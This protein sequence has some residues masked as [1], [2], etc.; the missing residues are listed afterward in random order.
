M[1]PLPRLLVSCLVC[2]ATSGLSPMLLAEEAPSSHKV[3]HD[4]RETH[5]TEV[6]QL[7][8]GG[9]NAEAY[10]SPEGH[11]LIYQA[12][13]PPQECDQIFRLRA[14]GKGEPRQVSTG[15]GRTTCAFFFPDGE[16]LLYASTHLSDAAC[17]ARPDSSQGY[18]WPIYNSFEIF[19]AK[20][21]GS[22]L[23]Q[24]T[25]N[26]AYD[27]EATICPRD[28]TILFTS[29]RDGDLELYRMDADGANVVRLTD[30]PGYD[31]GAFFSNDCS[32]IV[33]RASR[34]KG[35]ALAD[36]QRLLADQKVRPTAL[37]IWVAHADGSEPHQVTYLDAA[38][39][40]PYFFPDGERILFS[41][42]YGDPRGRE[43]DLWAINV[44]GTALER[45]SYAEQFDG[46]PMFSPDGRFLA[47][48][49]NRNQGKPGET[50]VYVARWIDAPPPRGDAAADHLKQAV[51]WLAADARLGRGIGSFELEESRDWLAERFAEL[52]LEPGGED[53]FF[54][55]FEVP[56]E[57]AV[58]ASTRLE[59]RGQEVASESFIPTAFSASA[60][61]SAEVVA[62][63]YGIS[64]PEHDHDDYAGRDVTGKIVLAR[65]FVPPGEVF[66]D[67][68]VER[69]YG[70][71]RYKAW[72]ARE[73]GAV[74]MLIADFPEVG[75]GGEPPTEAPL[76]RLEIDTGGDA[77]LP[78]VVV[79]RALAAELAPGDVATI[80]VKL[81]VTRRLAHNVVG[82]ISPVPFAIDVVGQTVEAARLPGAFL[83]GA[84]YDH[85]GLGGRGSLMPDV[86]EPHNGADDNASGTASLLEI[87]RQI[88]A[89]RGELRREVYIVAFSGEESGLRGSTALTRQPPPGLVIDEL[90]AMVNLDMVGR[91]RHNR[92][93]V[94]GSE[95]ASEWS[96]LLLPA[97][98][99]AGLEC[100]LSGDGFGP[101]DQTP[102]YAAGV[103]VLQLFTGSHGDYH[104]P[105][106]DTAKL[107][108][109]GMAR[110]AGLS[111]DLAMTLATREEPLTYRRTQS[112]EPRGDSRSY[113][114]S[115]G[116]IPD[117]TSEDVVGVLLAGVRPDSPAE[118]A[119][120][121]QGDLLVA[122]SGH[123]IGDIYDFVYVLRQ[124]KPGETAMAAVIRDGRRLELEVTFGASRGIQ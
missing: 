60:E 61:V 12:T 32:R 109:A 103:P 72:N 35:E 121:R 86:R 50:D 59:L 90:I 98:Q 75:P 54:H 114:A 96:E 33:W 115:L 56:V 108:F 62:V 82:K 99:R 23:R 15:L 123:E 51:S 68:A 25:D 47:F 45:I 22:D 77:G 100:K 37:E 16:R 65:R 79:T 106:D 58:G 95:S 17:P 104:K 31:G 26:H 87:A 63:G 110:I 27:A 14:D 21:D 111:A 73:H 78:V 11:E 39:F 29:T 107:N 30:V 55:A 44:D 93:A 8:F 70:G 67:S 116:T 38:S 102:F 119:G 2:S 20:L 6:R 41:S 19:S 48:A 66:S 85:L 120:I 28:G 5:L 81:D 46:F 124:A 97:C 64:A 9:E 43:F 101:S 36:Y 40:A 89:R 71:L 57:I 1:K 10:W 24:L 105:S 4:P 84:H 42:N 80:A 113:G 112:P 122:L 91:L 74:G 94:L 92:L 117:Y 83:I 18:V 69:R 49:S 118:R 52:G 13:V 88:M 3:L 76:P 53:G 34:P 7:T